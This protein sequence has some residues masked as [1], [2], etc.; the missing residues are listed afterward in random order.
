MAQAGNPRDLKQPPRE[1]DFRRRR[2]RRPDARKDNARRHRPDGYHGHT[3]PHFPGISTSLT[4]TSAR[5]LTPEFRSFPRFS[6]PGLPETLAG[7]FPKAL[8]A[9]EP[10]AKV[11]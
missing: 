1:N 9:Q 7:F 8:I 10:P 5:P 4:R 2:H 11:P 3:I 6:A